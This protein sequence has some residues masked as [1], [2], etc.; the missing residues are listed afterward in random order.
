MPKPARL[1]GYKLLPGP[2]RRYSTPSGTTISR[3]EYDSRRLQGAGWKNR[4]ELERAR[5]SQ[6]WEGVKKWNDRLTGGEPMGSAFKVAM[7]A[8]MHDAYEVEIRRRNLQPD[9]LGN[10]SDR[11][12][13]KLVAP[14]GP[15]A[16]LLVQMG[17]RDIDDRWNVGDTPKGESVAA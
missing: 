9:I 6:A 16:A 13:P 15:L 7:T 3:Y 11:D 8:G 4:G 14:D 17:I 12:D 1:K 2:A 10:V 5:R